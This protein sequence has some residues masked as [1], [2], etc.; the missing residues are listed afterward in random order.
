[1]ANVAMRVYEQLAE[2]RGWTLPE[3]R[4][5]PLSPARAERIATGPAMPLFLARFSSPVRWNAL[6]SR[7]R[8]A[9]L[10]SRPSTRA[11]LVDGVARAT[12]SEPDRGRGGFA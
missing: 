2:S 3:L 10:F 11:A 7:E 6:L 4:H 5:G 1:M 12:S 8:S 9:F